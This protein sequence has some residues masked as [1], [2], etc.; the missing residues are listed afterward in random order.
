[1]YARLKLLGRHAEEEGIYDD[2]KRELRQ[3]DHM[4]HGPIDIALWDWF[5][6]KYK[7]SVKNMLGG[8]K[9]N[10]QHMLVHIMVIGMA[11]CTAK[12]HM[13]ILLKNVLILDIKA[14]KFM[15][16]M[17]EMSKKKLIIFYMLLKVGHKMTL[18][19]DLL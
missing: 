4:G 13:Q 1:M 10:F 15:D 17:K 9:I 7:C 11:D 3:F 2:F 14:S 12:K 16:G 19:L 18:M 8:L 5:G 6:K